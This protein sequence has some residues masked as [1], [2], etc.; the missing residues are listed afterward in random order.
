MPREPTETEPRDPS[1]ATKPVRRA[2]AVAVHPSGRLDRVLCV[3]RPDDDPELPST[4]GLPAS[5]LR[6]GEDWEDAAR[7]VGRQKLGVE[8]AVGDVVGEDRTERGSYILHMREFRAEVVRGG[9]PDVPQPHAGTQYR[10]WRWSGPESLAEAARL[11]SLCSQ[12]F[13]ASAGAEPGR[14]EGGGGGDGREDSAT[15]G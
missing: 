4:W 11:G 5:T 7:R 9:A 3:L 6:E 12:I 8:L 14:A 2:V 1:P 15:P 13:L 10:D